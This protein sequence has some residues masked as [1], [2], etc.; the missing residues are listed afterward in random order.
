[1]V[2]LTVF[3]IWVVVGCFLAREQMNVLLIAGVGLLII[4]HIVRD[5]KLD[6]IPQILAD[7]LGFI[8]F[9]L[10]S[11]VAL[12]FWTES[13]PLRTLFALAYLGGCAYFI[14]RVYGYLK[15]EK[16]TKEG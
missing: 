1:M 13:L 12:V 7:I 2:L 11:Y 5:M 16:E 6:L 4:P 3:I 9:N 14:Y 8:G 10:A 15:R